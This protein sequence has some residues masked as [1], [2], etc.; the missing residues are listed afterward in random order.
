MSFGNIISTESYVSDP[1]YKALL[2]VIWA[3]FSGYSTLIAR[4]K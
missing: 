4:Y 3:K 2:S 1:L